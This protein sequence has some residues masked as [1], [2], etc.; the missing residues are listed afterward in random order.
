[1]YGKFIRCFLILFDSFLGVLPRKVSAHSLS[2]L[3]SL[4]FFSLSLSFLFLL[5]VDCESYLAHSPTQ[6]LQFYF[7]FPLP[8][9]PP[10]PSLSTFFRQRAF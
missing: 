3:V 9:P 6:S 7:F 2:I 8:F 10:F 1:M 5:L 4:I